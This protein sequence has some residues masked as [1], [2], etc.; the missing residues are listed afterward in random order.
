MPALDRG[1]YADPGGYF[2][3]SSSSG[4]S[5]NNDSKREGQRSPLAVMVGSGTDSPV[6][7]MR[8]QPAGPISP[9]EEA[10]GDVRADWSA[11]ELH[12]HLAGSSKFLMA[13]AV[14]EFL[15]AL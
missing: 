12:E 7:I 13:D 8:R 15:A 9:G 6:T 3:S 2:N 10:G 14:D 11:N 1:G 4:G 5:G